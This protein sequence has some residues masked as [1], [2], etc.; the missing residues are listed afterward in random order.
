MPQ[1][2]NG[3]Q[4]GFTALATGAVLSPFTRLRQLLGDT[5][6]GLS[7]EIQMTIG[8][9]R[10]V[11]PNFVAA[12]IKEAEALFGK[13]PL[14][15]GSDAL[16]T[17]IADWIDRRYKF[18]P[19]EKID[20]AR[21][22]LAVSGSR[23]GLFFAALPAM[24]RK[25]VVGRPVIAMC[26]PFYATY[27][28]AVLGV[29]GEPIYLNA[30]AETGHLPDLDQLAQDTDVLARMVALY[31]ASPANPQGAV[32]SADYILQAL[33]LARRHNFMLFFDECYSEIYT[34]TPPI[35]ALEVAAKTPCRFANLVV[36]NS[37]SKRS[38]LPG[39]RS[40]FCAGDGAFLD[41]L[42]EIRSLV[43]PQTPGPLQHAAAAVWADE[44]HVDTTRA[45]YA[46]K[47]LVC[48]EVLG[49]RFGYQ[50]P[51]AGFFLWLNV[52]Q[53]GGG[54]D[55]AVTLWKEAG[56]KVLPGAFLAQPDRA[57]I[58]PGDDYIRL[59]LVHDRNVIREALER[60]VTVLA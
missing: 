23:E 53:F 43:A 16:R 46:D 40:G 14:I 19:A 6:P 57:G 55:A 27:I 41:T 25:A 59:A 37:L 35:G 45:A 48:D 42:R 11:M 36:F 3:L 31:V 44:S 2:E 17:A 34:G 22:V 58:N 4:T 10:E 38:N 24:G 5:K 29:N 13:Y 30:T 15:Q 9:P 33:E 52:S 50:R 21:E 20:P 26:N 28:G 56:V 18:E 39:L 32:A 8:E 51:P 7:P 49:D 12:K 60:I 1:S 54:G 47:F